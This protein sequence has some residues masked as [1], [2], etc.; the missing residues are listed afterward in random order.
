MVRYRMWDKIHFWRRDIEKTC[1][2]QFLEEICKFGFP[3]S[4]MNESR[5]ISRQKLTTH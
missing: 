3:P 5:A 2:V 1:M 4:G